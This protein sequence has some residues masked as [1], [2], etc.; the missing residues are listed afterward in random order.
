MHIVFISHDASRTGAP[1]VLLHL[2]RWL[3]QQGVCSFSVLLL[4][5]GELFPQF[6]QLASTY[7]WE[8]PVR[9]YVPVPAEPFIKRVLKRLKLEFHQSAP[10]IDYA[11]DHQNRIIDHLQ[12]N[13]PQIIYGNTVVTSE[14]VVR[15]KSELNCKSV[16]HVHE[17]EIA[18]EDYFGE[19]KFAKTLPDIDLIISASDAVTYNLEK[20]FKLPQGRIK[21]VYEFVPKEEEQPIVQVVDDV[22]DSLSIPRDSSIVIGSGTY[23]WRK[24]P[25]VFVQIANYI[26]INHEHA[27]PYFVW[28][29]GDLESIEW[30]KLQY[31]IAR[32]KL[33]GHVQFIGKRSN[34]LDYIRAADLFLLTSREDPYPL[35]CL[36]AATLGKPVLCFDQSGGM[37]EFVENQNGVV[38]PYLRF[39]LMGEAIISLLADPERCKQLGRNARQ[40]VTEEHGVE[41]A[42][43]Q[44]FYILC[45]LANIT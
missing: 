34:A 29:G 11:I 44:I 33:E 20:K 18:I 35:V 2:L 21:K 6:E 17:L 31:D 23:E 15:L 16:C 40:K 32:F 28:V 19:E 37:P 24:S 14:V 12:K 5:G 42:G 43:K 7:V 30:K 1:I 10:V 22:L 39:D 41:K 45:E 3:K 36:E 27:M 38:V 25:D 9:P 8:P 13:N 4:K 26:K